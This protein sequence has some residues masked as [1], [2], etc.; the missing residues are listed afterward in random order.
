MTIEMIH[1]AVLAVLVAAAILDARSSKIPNWL[2]YLLLAIFGVKAAVFAD[3][4]D[5]YVQI[6]AVE[7]VFI[8]GLGG[9]ALGLLVQAR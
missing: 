7:V 2:I 9:F 6:G 1:Y 5:L 4:V 8:V 3:A